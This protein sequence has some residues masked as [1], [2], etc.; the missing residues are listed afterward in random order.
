MFL[1]VGT[2]R[3][4]LFEQDFRGIGYSSIFPLIS[5]AQEQ[6]DLE[7]AIDENP[8]DEPRWGVYKDFCEEHG[9]KPTEFLRVPAEL[10]ALH[11]LRQIHRR[12]DALFRG[13]GAAD[14][15]AEFHPETAETD[16]YWSTFPTQFL[17]M[18]YAKMSMR[19]NTFL[20]VQ[21]PQEIGRDFRLENE[22]GSTVAIQTLIHT[23]AELAL[24]QPERLAVEVGWLPAALSFGQGTN[25]ERQFHADLSLDHLFLFIE[26]LQ[27][28][29]ANIDKA[30]KALSTKRKPKI[31]VR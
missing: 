23:P 16:S 3:E 21:T 1:V 17:A 2:R 10:C 30:L 5:M 31:M 18:R 22:N 14:P 7:R 12:L 28:I 8:S 27:Q 24:V 4:I 20:Y 29:R 19:R 26:E 9:C 6:S 13:A 15:E 11:I 25:L